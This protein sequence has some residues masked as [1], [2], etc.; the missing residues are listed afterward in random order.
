MSF[1]TWSTKSKLVKVAIA[2]LDMLRDY[3]MDHGTWAG[4]AEQMESSAQTTGYLGGDRG[5][6]GE[7]KVGFQISG[8]SHRLEVIVK[9]DDLKITRL[10][11][12]YVEIDID[13]PSEL[14][15]VLTAR[16]DWEQA[17]LVVAL[18]EAWLKLA[19][20]LEKGLDPVQVNEEEAGGDEVPESRDCLDT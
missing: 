6:G 17:G 5:H 3:D 1:F 8:G 4:G 12:G 11:G 7:S 18:R 14:G 19:P 13:D 9:S 15:I 10:P 16:G 2:A 20:D